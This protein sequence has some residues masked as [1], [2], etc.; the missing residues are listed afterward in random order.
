MKLRQRL[1]GPSGIA[2]MVLSSPFCLPW[3][4][5]IRGVFGTLALERTDA[6]RGGMLKENS[7]WR[8]AYLCSAPEAAM[9]LIEAP[10]RFVPGRRAGS[11]EK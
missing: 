2:G 11:L 6:A 7:K 9:S 10:L 8:D 5:Q 3:Y 4:L 1:R